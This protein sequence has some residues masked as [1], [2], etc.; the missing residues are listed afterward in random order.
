MTRRSRL[1]RFTSSLACTAACVALSFVL[2]AAAEAADISLP[3]ARSRM[4]TSHEALKAAGYEVRERAA[5]VGAANALLWPKLEANARITRM[6]GPIVIDLEPVR[7]VILA[8]HPAVPGAAVPP[9]LLDVQ[10]ELFGRADVRLTWPLFTGGKIDAARSAADARKADAEASL[11]TVDE[12]L[13]TE[14]VRRYFGT[15]LARK[16]RDVRAGVLSALDEHVRDARRLEEE[17]FLSRAERLHADVARSDAD[18]EL[19][20]AEHDLALAREALANI[21]TLP[22]EEGPALDATTPLFVVKDLPPLE[23][24]KRDALVA[25]PS[26]A[27]L[28]AAGSLAGAGLAAESARWYPD[29]A[30]FGFRE[31]HERG[32]T[33]LDPTWA[34]GL[35]AR[36][37]LFDGFGREKS[38]VAARE[39]SARV[40]ALSSRARRDVETLVEKRYRE[41]RKALEQVEAFGAALELGRENVRVRTRAFEEG[42]ATSLDVVDARL[43]LARVEL[44][45]LAA[46][47]DFDVA[48]AELLEA[49]GQSERY[50]ALRAS[51]SGD[52]E[53]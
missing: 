37:T 13:S 26:L 1:P 23:E 30:A 10:D 41:S 53:K 15:R 8:L 28:A 14:L 3:E 12:S 33:L 7:Q 50:E 21:L 35:T 47:R 51:A 52:V 45:R 27:R 43:S 49:A 31:L 48:L 40:E 5:E 42:V 32:L 17:G 36:W 18:R 6:D 46:A 34:A 25:N 2:A 39:R 19:K 29:I 38:I 9:F 22:G 11:R 20:G 44:G 16:A 24:L 4:R